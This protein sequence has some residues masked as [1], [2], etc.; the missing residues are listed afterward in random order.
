[1]GGPG[2][3]LAFLKQP[4]FFILAGLVM[5]NFLPQQYIVVFAGL[6]M[7]EVSAAACYF[8]IWADPVS[9]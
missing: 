6:V 4:F 1:M 2:I 7:A 8:Y 3:F 5:A 9:I